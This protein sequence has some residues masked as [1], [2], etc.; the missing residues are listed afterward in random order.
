M[1]NHCWK[2]YHEWLEEESGIPWY[3]QEHPED[4]WNGRTCMRKAGHKGD[5]I[6]TPDDDIMIQFQGVGIDP[7]Y[8]P[9]K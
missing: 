2:D 8:K 1:S 6:W 3:N 7:K 4:H 9:I 5:H